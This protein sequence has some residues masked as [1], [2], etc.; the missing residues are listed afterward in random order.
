MSASQS[1]APHASP[2]VS[3]ALVAAA[4]GIVGLLI[5]VPLVSVFFEAFAGGVAAWWTALAHDPDTRHAIWLSLTGNLEGGTLWAFD[6][7]YLECS[8]LADALQAWATYPHEVR[9]WLA[10]QCI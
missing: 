9:D 8:M 1:R 5:V 7:G 10:D 4:V 3:A 6:R 2:A